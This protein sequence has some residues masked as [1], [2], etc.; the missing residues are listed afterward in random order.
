MAVNISANVAF[1]A[2][3]FPQ[4]AE[5]ATLAERA[6][7]ADPRA[8]CFHARH[9]L[10]QLVKRVYK[11]DK[12]LNPPRVTNL[13]GYMNEPTFVQTAG[14]TIWHN[15]EYIRK[16]GNNAVHGNKAPE[17]SVA[18]DVVRELYHVLYWAGRTYL[19]K[20][21]E[22][23]EGVTY[24]ESIIP[25][26][27]TGPVV[28]LEKLEAIA[29]QKDEAEDKRGEMETQVEQLQQRIAAIRAD[30]E[31]VPDTHDYDEATTRK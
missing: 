27:L 22:K 21:A 6:I 15:A 25:S 8:S 24:D 9:T 10:E 11:L 13:D 31:R 2:Q 1:L 14:Q 3:E 23:L 18:L 4:T 26:A 19:R 17:P 12:R 16:A 7:N 20:G 5:S 28:P 30:N 29:K